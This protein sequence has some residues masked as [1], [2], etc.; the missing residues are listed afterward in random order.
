[1]ERERL[2]HTDLRA[3]IEDEDLLTLATDDGGLSWMAGA[4]LGQESGRP[5]GVTFDVVRAANEMLRLI[6]DYTLRNAYIVAI[7]ST[8]APR[9]WTDGSPIAVVSPGAEPV[10]PPAHWP[11]VRYVKDFE[12]FAEAVDERRRRRH[13]RSV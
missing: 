6:Y 4:G 2:L 3:S 10:E 8:D 9:P 1:M 13:L 5:L 7:W 12:A 11:N